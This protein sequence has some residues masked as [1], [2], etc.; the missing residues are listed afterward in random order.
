[1][2]ENT[3]K[4]YWLGPGSKGIMFKFPVKYLCMPPNINYDEWNY[5]TLACG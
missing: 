4:D 3:E 5:F 1:M 2:T